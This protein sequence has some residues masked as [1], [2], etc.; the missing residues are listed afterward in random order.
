MDIEEYVVEVMRGERKA[1]FLRPLLS[2]LSRAYRSVVALRNAAYDKHIFNSEALSVPVISIGNL[3]VGGTGKTPLVH[4]LASEL[5]KTL[6]LA[7]LTRGFRS[8]VEKRGEM[9][10]ISA[11][12]GPLFSAEECGDEPYLLAQKTKASI[13]VGA[14]RVASGKAAIAEGAQ[15][16]LLDDGFQH[17][18][19]KR[20]YDIVVVDG[21]DPLARGNFLP[22]G[23]LRDSPQ[24][25]KQASL[26]VVSHARDEEH[27]RQV[28]AQLSPFTSAPV[29]GVRVQVLNAERLTPG[30]AALFCGIGSPQRFV[31]TVRDLKQEIV[32]TLIL[33]DHA[34]PTAAQLADFARQSKEKGARYL[35]CT[36]K[37]AVKVLEAPCSDPHRD[38]ACPRRRKRTLGPS[39]G[40]HLRKGKSM[41]EEIKVLLPKLGESIH[42]ATIV[43]W[44]K[45]I[46]ENVKLDEP[47][48][49]VST[50]KVNSEIPS[51]AAG[52][53][54]EIHASIDQ[55]LQVGQLIAV[56]AKGDS[57]AI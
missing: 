21:N 5:Q 17:R 14:D 13:W 7:I 38:A 8:R 11:G 27:V 54:K 6:R 3:T 47:L 24:R 49:E 25:L 35:L 34:K 32:D 55:E 23:F 26:I 51:P 42:S 18:R 43:Q 41:S 28:E 29:M 30:K 10:K 20:D 50:D 9:R 45:G 16:L 22:L 15:C 33:K 1:P 4:L 46:G 36:E 57:S 56:I 39:L 52:V 37:D 19:L 48:L 53:L 40:K 44:F 2:A 12:S 31:Q